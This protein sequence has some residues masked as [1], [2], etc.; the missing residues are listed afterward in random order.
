[1][2]LDEIQITWEGQS[3][4]TVATPTFSPA[5]GTYTEAQ[6]VTISCATTGATIYY[7]TDGSTP[8]TS[9][10]VYSS[11]IPVSSTTTIKAIAVKEGM[12]NSAVA[13]AIY[14]I[15][16]GGS[17][18]TIYALYSGNLVEG[19]YIIYY[20]GKAMK[21]TV[22]SNRLEYKEV[23]PSSDRITTSDDAIVWHIAPN[24]NY[25]TI[26]NE[27]VG[28]YAASTGAKNQAQLLPSDT[29]DM[30]LWT[31][32]GNSTYEFVNKK[33]NANNVND[34][35]RNNGSYGFACYSSE[36]GGALSLYRSTAPSIVANQTV[37]LA[38][39]ATS[40][41]FD[42]SITNPVTGTS[43]TATAN[44]D[45][46]TNVS[47][48]TE[49]VTF[50]AT[51]NTTGVERTGTITLQY[52]GAQDK[53]VTVT[54]AAITPVLETSN[55]P[56]TPF[57]YTG[58]AGSFDFTITNPVDGAITTATST[59]AWITNVAV[60]GNTVNFQV[61]Y[62]DG[63]SRSG[64][65]TLTY[66]KN[67][68]TLATATVTI[69]QDSNPVLPGGADN[70][71]TVAQAVDATPSSGTS[72]F[73]YVRGIVS[74]IIEIEVMQYHNARYYISDDGS[75][76]S[77]QLLAFYGRNI[78]NTDFYSEDE[79]L[80]GDE[81]VVYGQLK[82]YNDTDE[83][84]RGNYIVSL[85]RAVQPVTFNPGSCVTPNSIGVNLFT[86]SLFDYD[87]TN[88]SYTTNGE[89][90]REAGIDFE[91]AWAA[92]LELTQTTT[93]KAAAYV[94]ELRKWSAVTEAT[95]TIVPEGSGGWQGQPYTVSEALAALDENSDI[96]GAYVQG[97]VSRVSQIDTTLYY[98]ATYY[99]S[100][101][102]EESNE[103][104]V[105][106]GKYISRADFTSTDQLKPGD[107][108]TV[109]GDL[110]VYHGTTKEFKPKNYIENWYRPASIMITPDH[111]EFSSNATSGVIDVIY[112]SDI[113]VNAYNPTV[114]FC[115]A[116]GETATYDWLTVTPSQA[117]DW[118]LEFIL[119]AN[120]GDQPR[121]AYLRVWGRDNQS[122]DI[123]S[124][125][126][127]ITQS[128]YIVD[129]ATLDFYFNGGHNDIAA[130]PGLTGEY[131]GTYSASNTRL[132]FGNPSADQISML[133]LKING[134]PGVL[135]YDIKGNVM[136]GGTF[137]VQE[138][139]NGITYSDVASYSGL[140]NNLL[141]VEINNLSP[142]TRYIRWIYVTKN[143]GNVGVGN[144]HLY[145]PILTYDLV[146]NNPMDSET[147]IGA[148]SANPAG[149]S[150]PAGTDVALSIS[151]DN[152][153]Y[154]FVE[155]VVTDDSDNIVP[156][157]NDHFTMPAS[158][159]TVTATLVSVDTPCAY[160][161]ST[162]GQIGDQQSVTVGNA[163]QMPTNSDI[164]FNGQTFTFRG[165]TTNPDN[166][167]DL[168]R[169]GTN[170]TMMH[171]ETFYA[172]YNQQVTDTEAEK[173]YA[174]VTRELSDW[175]GDYMIVYEEG[176]GAFNGALE[177]LDAASNTVTV[178]I[179]NGIINATETMNAAKFAIAAAPNNN[180]TIKSASG[181]YIGKTVDSNGLDEDETTAYKNSISYN[182]DN[183]EID[184][185][186][187]GG[188]YLRFNKTSGQNR[189]R[190]YKS[191]TYTNQQPIQLYKY[192]GS[193]SNLYTRIFMNETADNITIEGPSIIPDGSVL[194]VTTITNNLGADRLIVDEGGQLV[195]SSDVNATVRKIITP[196]SEEHGTDNY[197]LIA[198]PVD[199][200]NPA[201]AGMTVDNFDLYTFDQSAQGEEWRNY[202]KNNFN[203][204]AGQGYLY[205]NDYGGFIN[206]GGTMAATAAGVTIAEVSGKP[207]AGWN[208]I[209]NPYPCNVTIDKPFYRLAEG[210]AAL[211][212]VATDNS[213]AIAPMEGVFVCADG[214]ETVSFTKAPTTSTTGGRNLLS[215]RVSRN[216]N[217]KDDRFD[218]DN[219]IVR[220]GEGD[221]LRKLVL[222][223]DLSQLYVAQEGT[224]Y[225]IVNAEAEGELPVSFR[226]ATNG[227]YTFSFATQG[228]TMRYLHLIDHK[229]G[230][231]VDL[232][233]TPSYTFEASMGD[234]ECRFKLVFACGDTNDGTETFAYYNGS[235]WMVS[236]EGEATLQ[237]VDMMGRVLSSQA[238]NGSTELNINQAQGVYVLRLINGNETKSQKIVVR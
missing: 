166:V 130:T 206:M 121:T 207:F 56:S 89:D 227:S 218:T 10:S 211:A 178:T 96:K 63:A 159:V 164:T 222:K 149:P 215:M 94:P 92:D 61:A 44:V 187:E 42:Y 78:N 97:I 3:T 22:S 179:A 47:V 142:S 133:V 28:K 220:F 1:M 109:Y 231:D 168:L 170:Y 184:I 16:G 20:S 217:S 54:Q 223:P 139:S 145:K 136:V 198:S 171:D 147:Q 172:V 9:S 75:T 62:N 189:F 190:Y 126:I 226:A 174:K 156:V 143:K 197:Y 235:Q 165:W 192:V 138:S 105:F 212:T 19:D 52:D 110:T 228:V 125:I 74:E 233:Q 76:N 153:S 58:T 60:S 182:E 201:T 238:I 6:N 114:Q 144:I 230:T 129:F 119:D 146:V 93:L 11:A 152:T 81:V 224:D 21:N 191:S 40:G 111:F 188:A 41:A 112:S 140:A 33:N 67:G 84:D 85:T 72:G 70:P 18:G 169:A 213:V 87:G 185:I 26:Y 86:E 160:V 122:N 176:N 107:Q 148:I 232:L 113:L 46:I 199:D 117:N 103:L 34:H 124:N 48:G 35:L 194:E 214:P 116:D 59:N 183:G 163:V 100:N 66:A 14:T 203:L 77:T 50:T 13:E 68:T 236:S 154:Y 234:F 53:T 157:E 209:G 155:W 17:D 36:T 158:N 104:Y 134:V 208:L 205:A 80:V 31:V 82:K 186:G 45:W 135:T 83:L 175:S 98:N 25:W 177:T 49:Q 38:H 219:A 64:E 225:A 51:A 151:Y 202:K 141:S 132:Q 216:R 27:E 73:V 39:D 95:Y 69:N 200:L 24:G 123:V 108:V 12:A 55:I 102:G 4:P 71:Y 30:S 106:R 127:S 90:P 118:G 195:T 23:T 101:N 204:A 5:A 173:Q 43:L 120:E 162:N 7:T 193:V 137:K 99:I 37:E 88:I 115:D 181:K 8:N 237:V 161:F 2:Y 79:L 210:G 196:Y 32:E 29:D 180:Y 229:T 128:E 150:I 65:I 15:E 221:M 57:A 167:T 91:D 131:L